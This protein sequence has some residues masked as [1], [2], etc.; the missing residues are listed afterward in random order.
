[1]AKMYAVCTKYGT[2]VFDG[3]KAQCERH[4]NRLITGGFIWAKDCFVWSME[5]LQAVRMLEERFM[6]V[7]REEFRALKDAHPECREVLEEV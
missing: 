1:M 4:L 6:F 7:D 2:S 3:T 5:Q